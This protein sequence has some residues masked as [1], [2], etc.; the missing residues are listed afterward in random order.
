MGLGYT[1]LQPIKISGRHKTKQNVV[2]HIS[3]EEI[4][5]SGDEKAFCI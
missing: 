3:V 4:D 2:Q 1:P 5:E